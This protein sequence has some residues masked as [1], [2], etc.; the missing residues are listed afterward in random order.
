MPLIQQSDFVYLQ[1]IF[2]ST[3]FR[4]EI[5]TPISPSFQDTVDTVVKAKV[6]D[7][8][9]RFPVSQRNDTKY[10]LYL[11]HHHYITECTYL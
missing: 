7:R 4:N 6:G 5:P 11:N 3:S 8:K 10:M 2:V 9:L 1:M